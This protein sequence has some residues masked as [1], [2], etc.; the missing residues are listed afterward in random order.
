MI[1]R[2][3]ACNCLHSRDRGR[4][5]AGDNPTE[6][7]R[8]NEI[9][10]RPHRRPRGCSP[11]AARRRHPCR[12]GRPDHGFGVVLGRGVVE[13]RSARTTCGRARSASTRPPGR[14]SPP[15]TCRWSVCTSVTTAGRRRCRRSIRTPG[16]SRIST[17]CVNDVTSTGS[18]TAD[19]HQV[20]AGLDVDLLEPG[21]QERS[22]TRPSRRSPT[23]WR[24]SSRTT[25]PAP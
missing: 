3:F 24:G 20:R 9:N 17:A 22:A 12:G 1:V 2:A 21:R 19:E 6:G 13:P 23:T 4:P 16:R 8:S 14:T 7:S 25:T 5:D 10:R 18:G 15:S 11:P